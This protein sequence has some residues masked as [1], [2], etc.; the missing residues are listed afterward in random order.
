MISSPH[1]EKLKLVR[2][3]RERKHREREGLFATEGEDLLTA[4]MAAGLEPRFVLGAAGGGLGGEEVEPELL[5]GVSTLGSGTRAIAV[6][7]LSWASEAKPPC[8]YLHAVADPGNV[9]AIVRTAHALTGG[10]V[11]LGPGCAD[12]FGPKAVRAS[13]GS[14]FGQPLLRAGVA[15]TPR[16]RIALVAH[17]GAM[18][19][20]MDQVGTVCLGAE[21][22]GLPAEALAECDAQVTI[23][24][25]EGAAES[26]NVAAAAAVV[27]ERISS[28]AMQEAAE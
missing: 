7:P 13:M 27:C 20:A 26:L 28:L 18:L 2:K 3:L 21:R 11:V 9:G 22:D 16:P 1:N 23:P 8:V 15:D 4:G 17:G 12:P 14:I 10:T 24:L 6:W 5:A 25:R 19:E